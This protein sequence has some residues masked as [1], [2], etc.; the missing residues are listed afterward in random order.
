M[1]LTLIAMGLSLLIFLAYAGISAGST[2]V[3]T[4]TI[5]VVLIL[6]LSFFEPSIIKHF[7]ATLLR[8]STFGYKPSVDDNKAELTGIAI[9]E[10]KLSDAEIERMA[11]LYKQNIL[12]EAKEAVEKAIALSKKQPSN[13]PSPDKEKTDL[14]N[15][16]NPNH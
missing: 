7:K 3:L 16:P 2:I 10:E 9:K 15:R 13:S 8:D 11:R 14:P 4:V 1:K 5:A 6:T 12:K